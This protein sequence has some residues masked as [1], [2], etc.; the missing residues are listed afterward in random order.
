MQSLQKTPMYDQCSVGEK[1]ENTPFDWVRGNVAIARELLAAGEK[2]TRQKHLGIGK[3]ETCGQFKLDQSESLH[4]HSD[5]HGNMRCAPVS[6]RAKA[7]K[8]VK[9]NKKQTTE[10]KQTHKKNTGVKSLVMIGCLNSKE[11]ESSVC[12]RANTCILEIAS[13]LPS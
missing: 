13:M 2:R 7:C 10:N 6:E 1:T 4:L 8:E 5:V 11:E 9:G 12:E 3:D